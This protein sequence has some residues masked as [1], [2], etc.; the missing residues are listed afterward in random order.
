MKTK[1][2]LIILLCSF[3]SISCDTIISTA[4]EALF[5]SKK[6]VGKWDFSKQNVILESQD[7]SILPINISTN[8]SYIRFYDDGTY[9]SLKTGRFSYGTWIFEDDTLRITSSTDQ[10]LFCFVKKLSEKDL[11]LEGE[12][13]VSNDLLIGKFMIRLSKDNFLLD[14]EEE[15]FRKEKNIWRNRPSHKETFQELKVRAKSHIEYLVA[16][17]KYALS[18]NSGRISFNDLVS[19]LQFINN[20]IFFHKEDTEDKYY[21]RWLLTFYD[22]DDAAKCRK[23]LKKTM[24]KTKL[25]NEIPDTISYNLDILEQML[26]NI[27]SITED[28]LK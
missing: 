28:K 8:N 6:F 4:Y 11:V 22:S 19:P 15:P 18:K 27:D 7:A 9:T 24:Y 20:G 25:H 2:I 5:P 10:K 21:L 3:I 17:H 1:S 23:L 14:E 26:V 12:N 13:F 16:F